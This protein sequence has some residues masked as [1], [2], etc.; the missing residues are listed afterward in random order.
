M[1]LSRR[2]A[3]LGT[4]GLAIAAC[5]G[6]PARQ[7]TVRLG[8]GPQGGV[9]RAY[10]TALGA[11]WQRRITGLDV[12]VLTTAASVEN[13]Q[14]LGRGQLDLAFAQA[15]V[16]ADAAAGRGPWPTAVPATALA[17]LY[18]DLIHVIVTVESGLTDLSQLAG[19]RVSIGA[20]GSGTEYVARRVLAAA[21]LG[22]GDDVVGVNL[23]LKAALDTL[24]AGEVDAALWSGGLP[25]AA[26]QEAMRD[27]PLTLLA[28]EVLPALQTE[29]PDVYADAFVPGSAY[30]LDRAVPT[31]SVPNYLV[32]SGLDS[33]VVEQLTE[34]LFAEKAALV[35]AHPEAR[36][37]DVRRAIFT[38]PLSLHPGALRYYRDQ[39]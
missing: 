4:V 37:L 34:A 29:F 12:E 35:G 39:S 15:D 30:G 3:L 20:V 26:V 31:V 7:Q 18:D 5:T 16:A 11:A 1:I 9:Y 2:E 25:T 13:L 19:R 17:R 24:V 36:N 21:G 22:I 33:K 38:E 8:T 23:T 6:S 14:M 32:A 28:V 10:G 27:T